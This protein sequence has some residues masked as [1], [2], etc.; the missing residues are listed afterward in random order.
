MVDR[1]LLPDPF[2]QGGP[3]HPHHPFHLLDS[4][5]CLTIRL[6]IADRRLL[7]DHFHAWH[8]VRHC[9]LQGNKTVFTIRLAHHSLPSELLHNSCKELDVEEMDPL[10]GNGS[11]CVSLSC[12]VLGDK[13]WHS[14]F[15]LSVPHRAVI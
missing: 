10:P 14:L 15:L 1:K 4:V 8:G 12:S 13:Y 6:V 5:F 3:E 7:H 9:L 2:F 11:R